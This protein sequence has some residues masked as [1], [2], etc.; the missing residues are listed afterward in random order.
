MTF[1]QWIDTLVEEKGIDTM[2]PFSVETERT[3]HLMT[4]STVIEAAKNAPTR[5]RNAIKTNLVKIDFANGSITHYLRHLA[6]GLAEQTDRVMY[7]DTVQ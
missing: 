7:G 2:M 1:A 5:E 3:T 4:Y 6:K